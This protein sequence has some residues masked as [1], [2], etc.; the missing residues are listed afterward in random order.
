MMII[1]TFLLAAGIASVSA[2]CTASDPAA[3]RAFEHYEPIR[4]ALSAD[5]MTGIADHATTLAPIAGELAG[6]DAGKAAERLAAAKDLAEAREQFARLS[7]ELV[8]IFDAAD[9]SG[10]STY[11]CTM[12]QQV[13]AQRGAELQNPYM[14]QAMATCGVPLRGEP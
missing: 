1:R 10:V 3:A 5:Q 13:W 14:G 11:R 12:N 6:E 4:A 7:Q 2:A 8:P 9:L